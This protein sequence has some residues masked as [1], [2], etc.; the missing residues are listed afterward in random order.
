MC[1]LSST[2]TAG[3]GCAAIADASSSGASAVSSKTAAG[4]G[5]PARLRAAATDRQKWS[6]VSS[7]SSS[8]S[9]AT[10][11][12]HRRPVSQCASAVVLPAPGGPSTRVT[13]PRWTPL[14]MSLSILGRDTTHSAS[15]GGEVFAMRNGSDISVAGDR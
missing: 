4:S 2:R 11:P 8:V 1:R 10:G 7:Y 15:R 13:A 3:A 14:S 6:A 12:R 9:Q 5:M